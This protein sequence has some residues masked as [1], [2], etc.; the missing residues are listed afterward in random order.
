MKSIGVRRLRQEASAVLRLVERG[1]SF[2]ITDRGRAVALLSPKP[3]GNPL[4]ALRAAGDVSP[5]VGSLEDLPPPL[6]LPAGKESPSSVLRRL[7][8]DER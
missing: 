1:E 3:G 5:A 4:D 8:A 6:P 2:E 7:R